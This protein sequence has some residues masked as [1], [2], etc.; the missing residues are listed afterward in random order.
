[1]IELNPKTNKTLIGCNN[2]KTN[3]QH[4]GGKFLK[5]LRWCW[6]GRRLKQGNMVLSTEL[7]S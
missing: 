3:L 2:V 4:K 1:M 5:I 7:I 6:V